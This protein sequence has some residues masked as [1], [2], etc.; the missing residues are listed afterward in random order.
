MKIIDKKTGNILNMKVIFS[1]ICPKNKKKYVAL[2]YQK[3][4]FEKNSSYNNLD[5]LEIIKEDSNTIY[6][7]EIEDNDWNDVKSSL[8]HEIFSNLK[9]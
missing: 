5:L 9:K 1:F 7:T 3:N 6:V 8:Q 2:D 4:V